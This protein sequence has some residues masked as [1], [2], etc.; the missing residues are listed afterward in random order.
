MGI[1]SST[2][3]TRHLGFL[4]TLAGQLN[5]EWDHD[6]NRDENLQ[7]L[8]SM[9]KHYSL[10][11]TWTETH[12]MK[13]T[14]FLLCDLSMDLLWTVIWLIMLTLLAILFFRYWALAVPAYAMVTLVLA[15]SF[16]IGLNF[17]L[18]PSSTSL[19]TMFGKLWPLTCF[20]SNVF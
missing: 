15:L 4:T 14:Y 3:V 11:N 1:C 9:N 20:S 10:S 5:I 7:S 12:E 16:S 2:L 13:L 17:M 18:T 19:N 6:I 8:Q